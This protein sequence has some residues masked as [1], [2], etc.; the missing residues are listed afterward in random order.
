MSASRSSALNVVLIGFMGCGKSVIGPRLATLLGFDFLDTDQLIVEAA[1]KSI[2]DIFAAEGEAGFRAHETAALQ[3]LLAR[4]QLR[5]VISTGGGIVTQPTNEAALRALGCLLW[6]TSSDETLWQRVRRNRERPLLH[7][8]D[9]RQTFDELLTRRRPL[10]QALADLTIDTTGLTV[11]E[12]AYG[13][14][15]SVRVHFNP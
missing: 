7:T 15:E 4:G 9:P 13:I 11:E 12:A 10:Y 6:L 8:D 1:G 5:S 2:P 3:S 14:S